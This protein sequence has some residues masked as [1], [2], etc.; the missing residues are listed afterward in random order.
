MTTHEFRIENHPVVFQRPS[1]RYPYAWVGHI[2]FA[3]LAVDLL[4]PQQLLELG[5]DSGNSY[6]AFCQAVA[7]LNS[8]TQCHAVDSWQGDAQAGYYG[9]EVLEDLRS[10][11]DPLYSKFSEL[12]QSDFD[13][14]CRQFPDGSIDLLHID[15]FHTYEAV[16][17][18]FATWLPKLSERAVVL[19]HDTQVDKDG[20]GVASFFAEIS[21][22]YP[23]FE[24][25]HSNGLAAIAVGGSV[26][27]PF[28]EFMRYANASS[29]SIRAYF[30]ALAGKLVTPDGEML[31]ED[32]NPSRMVCE[33]YYRKCE[34]S[35]S[36]DRRISLKVPEVHG[37]SKFNFVIPEG[38]RPDYVRIDP[39]DFPGVYGFLE[40]AV[41]NPG[42]GSIVLEDLA[43]RLGYVNGNILPTF[44]KEQ[45]LLFSMEN[46]PYLEIAIGDV[47]AHLTSAPTQ[48]LVTLSYQSVI[49]EPSLRRLV[50]EQSTAVTALRVLAADQANNRLLASE[51]QIVKSMVTQQHQRAEEVSQAMLRLAQAIEM[52]SALRWPARLKRF[53]WPT[54]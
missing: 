45:L 4:R 27:E 49:C 46:D 6:M 11:H 30:E 34:E 53:F 48:I 47:L 14:A 43:P 44:G 37:I 13:A 5:T 36:S 8:G 3:Y 21:H 16:S 28:M 10:R 54:H 9:N 15:G 42:H 29:D 39:T 22:R 41:A 20:F 32:G 25:L 31:S 19:L 18:D 40:V 7:Y 26:P 33:L 1:L 23:H 2:P 38:V 50:K 35:Y 12:I 17:H 24:F 52:E 51:L